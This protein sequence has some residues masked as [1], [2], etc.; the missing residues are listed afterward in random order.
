M[1][2]EP[3]L[4]NGS[5]KILDEGRRV[6]RAGAVCLGALA[7]GLDR[8]FV[9]AVRQ[10]LDCRGKVVLSGIGKAGIIANKI[11]GTLA[12]TGTQSIYV[13]PSDALHGDLGRILPEDVVLFLSNSGASEELVRLIQPIRSIGAAILAI[14][15]SPDSV[16]AREADVALTFGRLNEA[17]HLGLAPTTSTTA[18][19]ALGDALAMGVLAE[20]HFSPAEFARYHPGGALGRALLRVDEV[21]RRGDRNP[22][23]R[24]SQPLLEVL[25]VM[26]ATKGRPGAAS[27]VDGQGRLTGFYTDGDFRRHME[28]LV[29]SGEARSVAAFFG[30]SIGELMTRDPRTIGAERLAAEAMRVMRELKIDQL[31]VVDAERRP[32]GLID[33]QDLLDVRLLG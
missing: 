27:L 5:P 8:S 28:K 7:D 14:T 26:S 18:M 4:P 2:P 33:V 13:H 32:V 22:V 1:Q 17:G 24:D 11:S 29:E 31:P 16:L 30:T 21:M 15:S 3:N 6:L 9:A 10:L 12:S 19:L 20:R 23:A 25:D